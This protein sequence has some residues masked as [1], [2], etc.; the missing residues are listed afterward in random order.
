M[1]SVKFVC[2]G[3]CLL[4]SFMGCLSQAPACPDGWTMF[5]F[6]CYGFA[7]D[8]LTATWDG[9]RD[10]CLAAGGDLVNIESAEENSFIGSLVQGASD[11]EYNVWIGFVEGGDGYSNWAPGEPNYEWETATEMIVTR[12]YVASWDDFVWNDSDGSLARN[13]YVCEAA[14]TCAAGWVMYEQACYFFDASDLTA[15]LDGGRD[16]CLA[17]G[18]DLV[19]IGSDEEN[20][21]VA[22]LAQGASDGEYNVWIGFNEGDDGYSNWAPGEPNY[23]WETA[24]E[25]IITRKYVASWDDFVWN[26]SDGSLARNGYVCEAG[27]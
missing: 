13:G 24:T 25:M 23:E 22:S 1:G 19:S 20:S 2:F 6:S 14:P 18:S 15:T 3:L 4:A 21:F 7:A 27:L 11:G 26:D 8:Q 16:V 17:A 9:A 5:G 10:V 12:K